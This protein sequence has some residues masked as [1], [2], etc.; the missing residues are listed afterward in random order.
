MQDEMPVI[1]RLLFMAIVVLAL[2]GAADYIIESI[3]IF[4]TALKKYRERNRD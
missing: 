3:Q 1:L 4:R 2:L